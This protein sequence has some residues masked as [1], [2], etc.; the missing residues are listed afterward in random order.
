MTEAAKHL[1]PVALELG[2]KCPAVI[3]SLSSWRFE[4]KILLKRII[5]AKF[6]TCSGQGIDYMLVE[7]K[8]APALI[9]LLKATTQEMFG[10]NPRES[11]NVARIINKHHFD[12]LK[13]LPD[14][15]GVQASVVYG[16]S[17]DEDKL[18]IEPTILADP[19][20]NAAIM[21]EE[22][23][24]PLLPIIR[25]KNI[26]D[27][28]EF[29]NSRPKTLTIYCFSTNDKFMRRVAIDTSSGS[30]VF[31]DTV[32]QYAAETVPF[33]G[34]GESGMGRYHGKFSFDTF[35]H[36]KPVIK[37]PCLPDFWFR[38]PPWNDYKLEL[39]RLFFIFDYL[40][41]VLAVLGSKK[42]RPLSKSI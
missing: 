35:S 20:L 25:L 4:R 34:V 19:P 42:P 39:F 37:R 31:N 32:I 23:F 17:M 7:D 12:R 33:R 15:D 10:E 3:D 2:G 18:Y 29:I 14:E 30:L 27:S 22:I 1:T 26:E 41:I 9:E 40:G 8:F 11:C 16:G 38:Y 6:G 13:H 28:I 21:T 5:S 24:G 36:E